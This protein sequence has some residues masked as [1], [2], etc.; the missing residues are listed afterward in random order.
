[1]SPDGRE[2]KPSDDEPERLSGALDR[3][4]LDRAYARGLAWTAVSK[5]GVQIITWT[6][7]FWVV[8]L[9]EPA[10]YGVMGVA[11]VYVAFALM[12]SEAGLGAAVLR[13]QKL[14]ASELRQLNTIALGLGAVMAGVSVV[15]SRPVAFFFELPHLEAVLTVMSLTFLAAGVKVVPY[16]LLRRDLR[17]RYLAF[18]D[19]VAAVMGGFVTLAIALSNPTYWAL[20]I[21]RTSRRVHVFANAC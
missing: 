3:A 5:W 12:F 13:F 7:T 16:A 20:V 11:R 8:R 4:S 6:I 21:G 2:F 18:T 17:Y 14:S 9:L 1:V 15:I 19:G 10:D